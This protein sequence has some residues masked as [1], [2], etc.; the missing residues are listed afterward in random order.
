MKILWL[1]T[2]SP[3]PPV[4]G[5]RLLMAHTL[6]A[7]SRLGHHIHVLVPSLGPSQQPGASVRERVV[8]ETVATRPLAAPL[9]A[10]LALIRGRPTSA[11]RHRHPA[12]AARAAELLR[13]SEFDAIHVEQVQALGSLPLD[14]PARWPGVPVVLR[15]QNVESALWRQAADYEPF[16]LRAWL[17]REARAL[18]AFEAES[19]SR[20]DLTLALTTHDQ[21]T[22]Q[23]LRPD[24]RVEWLRAPF[25]AMLDAASRE[26]D[27]T[28]PLVV[29][30]D[31]S[32][33]PN[34]DGLIDFLTRVWPSVATRHKGAKLHLYAGRH[35][36][37][38]APAS[39]SHGELDDSREAFASH[40][41]LVVPL[42]IASGVR[43]KILEAWA[44]GV[45]VVASSVAA[46]GLDAVDGHHLFVADDAAAL[47]EAIDQLSK[48]EVRQ[49]LVANARAFL[50]QHHDPD[51]LA[52]ELARNYL[53]P[54][55]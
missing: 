28:P 46:A 15:A 45:P 18:A 13:Q 34:R 54:K 14:L 9:A 44:R 47:N 21:A 11:V 42:R 29:L 40:S 35:A 32:W 6:E 19:L 49:R 23:A 1:A 53:Q 50:A 8:L 51:M 36:R 12:V 39:E 31:G 10:T 41:I 55:S 43:M 16:L 4:D 2:K 5:G 25:P 26:L 27:G 17:K 38:E 52:A 48:P 20:V 37:F 7:L 24:A 22:L 33:R 30:G 3:W